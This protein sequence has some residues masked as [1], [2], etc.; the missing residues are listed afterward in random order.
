P[1]PGQAHRRVQGMSGMSG[2]KGQPERLRRRWQDKL[3]DHVIALQWSPTGT[4]LAAAQVSGP[5]RVYDARTG[6]VMLRLPGHGFGTTDLGFSRDGTH[7]ATC[8]QDGKVKFWDLKTGQ[9]K[10]AVAGSGSAEP[11]GRPFGSGAWVEHLAWSPEENL[12]ATAA[13]K[14]LRLWDAS[15]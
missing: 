15:G 7:F 13:G 11:A 12:L 5:V 4:R 3:G 9:E 8:G 10:I 6:T 1:Q 2:G 14:R